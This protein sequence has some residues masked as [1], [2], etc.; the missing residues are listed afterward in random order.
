M[1]DLSVR[2]VAADGTGWEFTHMI[3]DVFF[4]FLGASYFSCCSAYID[5]AI[6]ANRTQ[7]IIYFTNAC[8]T[9]PVSELEKFEIFLR[10]VRASRL[11]Q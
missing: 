4:V 1:L 7:F 11:V 3:A 9:L 8:I 6:T 5:H 2:L 10:R